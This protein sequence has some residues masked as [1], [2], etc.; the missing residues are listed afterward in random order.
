MAK[1]I[2][3]TK[4]FGNATA[5]VSKSGGK[6]G[7]QSEY[8]NVREA[9]CALIRALFAIA[10][11][12]PD[13]RECTKLDR[14]TETEFGAWK[15]SVWGANAPKQSLTTYLGHYNRL[16]HG[17]GPDAAYTVKDGKR[18]LRADSDKYLNSIKARPVYDLPKDK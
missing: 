17:Y 18:R 3:V 15:R 16:E 1:Q 12:W 10:D 9:V 7:K 2:D 4:G 6:S 14:T 5:P 13:G 8:G 11:K